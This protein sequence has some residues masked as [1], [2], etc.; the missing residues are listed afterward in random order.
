MV[1]RKIGE[2]GDIEIDAAHAALIQ[3]M[4]G[5]FHRHGPGTRRLELLQQLVQRG[6]IRRGVCCRR[7]PADQ[8]VAQRAQ[9][10]RTA[11]AGVERVGDPVRARRLAV[12]AGDADHPQASRRA[13]IDEIGDDAQPP[14]QAFDWQLRNVPLVI[15]GE[16]RRL[17]QHRRGASSDG[18]RHE[19]AAIRMRSR[20]R[21][22]CHARFDAAAVC[23]DATRKRAQSCEQRGHIDRGEGN[24]VHGGGG[25]V[26]STISL[27]SGG[28]ITLLSGASVGTPSMRSADPVTLENTG[29]ATTPP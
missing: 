25:Q 22:E 2:E 8:A 27:P 6:S 12:G 11:A 18:I 13:A 5:H 29:A 14:L 16:S 20:I 7:D 1:A 9:D 17:P 3:T 10:A 23:G 28:R 26:S 15:P 24:G 19:L 21:G 4:R